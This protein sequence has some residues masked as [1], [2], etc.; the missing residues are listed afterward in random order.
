MLKK[1]MNVYWKSISEYRAIIYAFAAFSILIYHYTSIFSYYSDKVRP[2]W[3]TI[4]YKI[5]GSVGVEIFMF[6]SGISLYFAFTKK[7]SLKDFYIRRLYKVLL[8]YC[9]IALPYWGIQYLLL[10]HGS[11]FEFFKDLFFLS[12]FKNGEDRFWFVIAIVFLYAIYPVIYNYLFKGE[13]ILSKFVFLEVAI[14]TCIFELQNFAIYNHIQIALTRIPIFILGCYYGKKVFE[15][16]KISFIEIMFSILAIVVKIFSLHFRIPMFYHRLIALLFSF[17]LCVSFVLFIQFIS[18]IKFF[19]ISIWN[20]LKKALTF[21]GNLSLELYLTNVAIIKLCIDFGFHATNH[22]TY[23]MIIIAGGLISY[24]LMLFE[25]GVMNKRAKNLLFN[26][27]TTVIL[28]FLAILFF[29]SLLNLD[30]TTITVPSD[31]F[32]TISVTAEMMGYNWGNARILNGYYGYT[33]MLTYFPLF[34]FKGLIKN[35]YFFYQALLF[36]NSLICAVSAVI[37]YKILAIVGREKFNKNIYCLLSSIAVFVP[38]LFGISQLTNNDSTFFLN[39]MLAIYM[40]LKC[41]KKEQNKKKIFYS[42]GCALF[43]VLCIA[44]NNRGAVIIITMNLVIIISKVLYKKWILSPIPYWGSLFLSFELH[45]KIAYPFFKSFY[46]GELYNTESGL[47]LERIPRILTNWADMKAC[48]TA[49]IGWLYSFIVSTYGLG[50]LLIVLLLFFFF[51]TILRKTFQFELSESVLNLILIFW[52]LGTTVLCIISFLDSFQGI[53]QFNT[54]IEYN[55]QRADK[56]FYF[57]YYIALV[58]L[59]ISYCLLEI[60]KLRFLYNNKY[61]ICSL[62]LFFFVILLFHG[63]VAVYVNQISYA[64]SSTNLVGMILGNWTLNYKYGTVLSVRFVFSTL[65]AAI[66]LSSLYCIVVKNLYKHWLKFFLIIELITCIIWSG[67]YMGP[68]TYVWESY[69][70]QEIINWIKER[71]IE[72]V[73]VETENLAF[74]YQVSLPESEVYYTFN[75]QDILICNS[76]S[77]IDEN[78]LTNYEKIQ[79]GKASDLWIRKSLIN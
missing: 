21:C 19:R 41:I 57:R 5:I 23:I 59:G 18:E 12:F 53:L 46:T 9:L 56:L 6:I 49:L 35:T 20:C 33:A 10:N 43:C 68:R 29:K 61:I 54:G 45:E 62:G 37:I 24:L 34:L 26:E 13:K 69:K 22:I 40:V 1:Q 27:R 63:Y 3:A 31:E 15:N 32:N 72:T 75:N 67:I 42:I 77:N 8:P 4:Y 38:Q 25:K 60:K 50:L 14:I 70:E 76:K 79:T 2:L 74:L 16:K 44:G 66:I 39:H 51:N 65:L 17:A 58:P 55:P 78:I 36:V 71:K 52:F 48:L 47:I 7:S 64:P 28:M 73:Y 30:L 11:V